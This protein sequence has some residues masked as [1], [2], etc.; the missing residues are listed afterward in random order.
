MLDCTLRYL[1]Q[2]NSI[3]LQ[4]L[5][6]TN[7]FVC[8]PSKMG[9]C[10]CIDFMVNVYGIRSYAIKPWLLHT[11]WLTASCPLECT[12]FANLLAVAQIWSLN[13]QQHLMLTDTRACTT[14]QVS[15]SLRML[16]AR[17]LRN[18]SKYRVVRLG[19]WLENSDSAEG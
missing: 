15:P 18:G 10:S 4:N 1:L 2:C 17:K 9:A 5:Q 8:L 12:L 16:C 11:N 6:C 3:G 7:K 19:R 14:M 13:A